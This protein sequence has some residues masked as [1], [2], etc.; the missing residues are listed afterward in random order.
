[1]PRAFCVTETEPSSNSG[2]CTLPSGFV[3][4]CTQVAPVGQLPPTG[5]PLG[6]PIFT[7]STRSARVCLSKLPVVASGPNAVDAPVAPTR[8]WPVRLNVTRKALVVEATSR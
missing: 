5:M 1:M 4:Y 2:C 8:K 6:S 7:T 3:G